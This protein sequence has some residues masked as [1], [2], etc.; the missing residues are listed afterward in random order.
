MTQERLTN[1]ATK[2]R[3]EAILVDDIDYT[4][5]YQGFHK[6][7]SEKS[8]NNIIKLTFFD[9]FDSSCFFCRI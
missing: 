1:L 8:E 6:Q 2:S 7:K 3:E 4:W 5:N 9:I